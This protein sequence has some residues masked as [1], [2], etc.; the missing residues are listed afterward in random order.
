M[1]DSAEDVDGHHLR[2]ELPVKEGSA[3]T[4]G[5]ACLVPEGIHRGQILQ[6]PLRRHELGV[7]ALAM[8]VASPLLRL[9]HVIGARVSLLTMNFEPVRQMR[10]RV[11]RNFGELGQTQTVSGMPIT[12]SPA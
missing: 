7:A 11:A 3:L 5:Q 12:Q 2:F 9:G 10:Y 4:E 8:E 6:L 1:I